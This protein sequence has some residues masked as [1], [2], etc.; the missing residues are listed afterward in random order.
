MNTGTV[1]ILIHTSGTGVLGD[2]AIGAYSSDRIY[3]DTNPEQIESL[4][5]TQPHRC[6]DVE[7]DAADAEG[8]KAPAISNVSA[9]DPSWTL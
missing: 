8:K 3:D 7:I 9:I 6:V 2:N 1:P 5:V 4:P